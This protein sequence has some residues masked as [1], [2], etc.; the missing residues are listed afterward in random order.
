[1]LGDSRF[2]L[3][4]TDVMQIGEGRFCAGLVV[5]IAILSIMINA[6]FSRLPEQWNS[7]SV[8]CSLRCLSTQSY[9]LSSSTHKNEILLAMGFVLGRLSG[10]WTN[11]A[12]PHYVTV[13]IFA[14]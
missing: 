3:N 7:F 13:Y 5:A 4:T 6:F 8:D 2:G 11:V 1:M 12:L 9:L 14:D 10:I